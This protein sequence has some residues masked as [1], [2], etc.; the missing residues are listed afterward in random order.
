[1]TDPV[2]LLTTL[3]NSLIVSCQAPTGHPERDSRVI[4]AL[5]R[6]AEIG[7][8]AAIRC[9]G[10]GGLDDI[11]AVRAAVK[12][13]VIGL[14]KEGDEGVYITP[15]QHS[16]EA[17]VRAGSD[18]VAFDATGRPRA[19]GATVADAARLCR[20][21]GAVSMAD[22]S[23]LSEATAAIEAGCDIVSTT[24]AGYTPASRP[25][26]GPDIE[27]VREIRAA[28][29]DVFLVAEGRYASPDAVQAARD[30]GASAVVVGTAITD[31]VAATRRFT[32]A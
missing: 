11:R 32:S 22:I 20:D 23:T 7:G 28:H 16:I 21:L 19:D 8:A 12:V 14:T 27:L 15:S 18:V 6:A 13:P 1:M 26:N 9:G 10:Y 2:A 3:R 25:A 24:L 31:I 17:C 5:A 30:A 4:A 29:P